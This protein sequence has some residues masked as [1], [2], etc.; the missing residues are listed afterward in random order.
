MIQSFN[1]PN[2]SDFQKRAL[3]VDA[4]RRMSGSVEVRD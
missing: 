4:F 2:M 3:M 1:P